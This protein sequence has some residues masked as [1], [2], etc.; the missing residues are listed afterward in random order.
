MGKAYKAAQKSTT[1]KPNVDIPIP[2]KE[3]AKAIGKVV[4]KGAKVVGKSVAKRG[5][6]P[7]PPAVKVAAVIGLAAGENIRRAKEKAKKE[8]ATVAAK[9]KDAKA[10]KA[11]QA[12]NLKYDKKIERKIPK[13]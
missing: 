10:N 1:A 6:I 7:A 5:I 4:S 11:R 3:A 8:K 2:V 9:A 12:T 13:R